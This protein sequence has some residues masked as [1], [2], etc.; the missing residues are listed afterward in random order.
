MASPA[1]SKEQ[2]STWSAGSETGPSARLVIIIGG[3]CRPIAGCP[4]DLE[5]ACRSGIVPI[6]G[7]TENW[8]WSLRVFDHL[9]L[10]AG[11][12]AA[13]VRFYQTVLAPLGNP[14]ACSAS[15]SDVLHEPECR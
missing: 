10:C 2:S 14:D 12:Y 15:G 8:D 3:V 13:S 4:E 1:C 6:V 9:D 7:M 5:A 11:D